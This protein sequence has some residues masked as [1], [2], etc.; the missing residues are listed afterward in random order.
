MNT[1]KILRYAGITS[2]AL[3]IVSPSTVFAEVKS[4]SKSSVSLVHRISHSLA[5]DQTYTANGSAGYKWGRNSTESDPGAKW[6]ESGSARGG[7]KWGTSVISESK[8]N[9]QPYAKA[10][11][12]HWDSMS[13]PEQA[14]NKWGR[15]N[16]SEQTANKWGRRNFSEQTA[17][18]WGRR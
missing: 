11:A 4:S 8:P 3:S 9:Q 17:N 7:Y 14:A 12:Y 1:F 5:T 16:F 13:S 18:K 6:A 15:R 2:L 10:A